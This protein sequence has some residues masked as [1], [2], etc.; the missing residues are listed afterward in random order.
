MYHQPTVH[1]YFTAVTGSETVM[2]VEI[3]SSGNS[4]LKDTE[5]IKMLLNDVA[6][7]LQGSDYGLVIW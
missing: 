7:P 5:M 1:H 4:I 6:E 3:L 2:H